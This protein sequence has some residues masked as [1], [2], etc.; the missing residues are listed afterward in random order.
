MQ[1]SQLPTKIPLPFANSGTKNTIPTASQIGITPGAAS[2]TD[3]FPPLTMTPLSAG[4]VPP[5]GADFNGILNMVTAVQQWQCAGGIFKYDSAFSTAIGGYPKGAILQSADGMSNW[6]NLVDNNTTNPDSGGSNWMSLTGGRLLNIQ[7]FTANGT[8]TPTA[9]TT[10]VVVEAIGGGGGSGGC[11]A[12]GSGQQAFTGGGG[13]GAYGKG[14]FTSG[15]SGVAVTIGQAGAAGAAGGNGGNGGTSSFGALLSASGGV[16]SPAGVANSGNT[17]VARALGGSTISGANLASSSGG[18]GGQ[19]VSVG[20][21]YI[22]GDFGGIS[23]NGFPRGYGAGAAGQ[24]LG[25]SAG[26]IA[27]IAGTQGIVIIFEYA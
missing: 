9:G 21:G 27:G 12:T 26:A 6:L 1:A 10:S 20:I 11:A 14:R 22:G 7:V 13:G 4:G 17:N 15:F 16:G 18:N 8:Y 5:A 25:P 3:G 24:Y 2:L 19:P 23:G